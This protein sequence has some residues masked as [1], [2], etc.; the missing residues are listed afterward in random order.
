[1]LL[2]IKENINKEKIHFLLL[3]RKKG[4]PKSLERE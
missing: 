3:R 2:N 1:M 4:R